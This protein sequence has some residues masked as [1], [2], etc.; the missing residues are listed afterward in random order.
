MSDE[1][2]V[3]LRDALQFVDPD[4]TYFALTFTASDDGRIEWS[5]ETGLVGAGSKPYW[6]LRAPVPVRAEV[7]R[8]IWIDLGQ[9]CVVVNDN[10]TLFY[11]LRLGGNGL[12]E[13]S[14]A[15]RRF[16]QF[17][18]PVECVPT[19]WGVRQAHTL[20]SKALQHAPTRK[21][22]MEVLR[23]DDFRC[24]SCGRRASDYVDIELHVHHILPHGKGG[25]TEAGNLITLCHT[26]HQGL[27][28]H[29]ELK[30]FEMVPGGIPGPD[31]DIERDAEDY[32]R[33]VKNYRIIS[34]RQIEMLRLRR[35]A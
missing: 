3:R 14:I 25:L 16:P 7:M 29:L 23:R 8:R 33:G 11:F 20:P 6:E 28:P 15:K 9:T 30:L 1:E 2:M 26:C 24:R 17:F 34:E 4:S 32:R 10:E 21:L 35:K 12:I 18:D 19:W 13:E 31:V 27:D 22:R 5:M